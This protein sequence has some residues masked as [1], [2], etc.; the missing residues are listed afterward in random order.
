[1][2]GCRAVVASGVDSR[3]DLFAY[4]SAQPLRFFGEHLAGSLGARVTS[5][6][7][8]AGALYGNLTWRI[9]PPIVD[10]IGAVV[11][12][13]TIDPPMAVALAAFVVVVALVIIWAGISGRTRHQVFADRAA[14]TQGELIDVVGNIWTVKAFSA[15][16][17][18]Q[19]RL[20]QLLGSE[21]VAHRSSWIYLERVRVLHDVFLLMMAGAMLAWAIELWR[22]SQISAGDVVVVSALT[23]RIL[24]GSRD[25]ALSWVDCAQHLGTISTTLTIIGV[26]PTV[27]DGDGS[28]HCSRPLEPSN[29]STWALAM[30]RTSRSS[31]I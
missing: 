19:E 24:H 11:V 8:A 10:L 9:A 5:T 16:R 1:M 13:L 15:R 29:A 17:R 6:A 2:L 26:T 27:R 23:F 20:A 25:L 21:A 14:V 12:F 7:G 18:E 3:L 28:T 4:L 22:R 30:S 31:R